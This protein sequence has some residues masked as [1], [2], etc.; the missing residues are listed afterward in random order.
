[1]AEGYV[2]ILSS[3]LHS[4]IWKEPDDVVRVWVT[5]LAMADRDGYV[6]ASLDG[7]AH[8]ARTV[9]E[10][11]VA[12]CLEIFQRPDPGSRSEEFE[13]RR[14]QRVDRGWLVLNY[15]KIR[16]MHGEESSK[17]RK[18]RWWSD[19]KQSRESGEK[20][21]SETSSGLTRRTRMDLSMD[22]DPRSSKSGSPDR[23]HTRLV[24]LDD[25]MRRSMAP[26][27]DLASELFAAWQMASG[28]SGARLDGK[29]AALFQRLAAEGVTVDDVDRATRG[30]KLDRW[31]V[32]EAK[33]GAPQ[34]LGSADQR[35]KY[36]ELLANP[37]K[38]KVGDEKWGPGGGNGP[39]PNNP[40][41]RYVPK[42]VLRG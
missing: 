21:S 32:E 36:I 13:G 2:K 28:K 24:P 25:P 12:E 29:R 15:K 7:I 41:N 22:L 40:D 20:E 10:E 27:Y 11:R 16:D 5:I 30:A 31:A 34:I 39:Q 35:E 19:N 6:G 9:S 23:A 8:M 3:I 4:S 26:Q 17:A 14:V 37:P 42:R 1:M 38:P 33:M 18:R